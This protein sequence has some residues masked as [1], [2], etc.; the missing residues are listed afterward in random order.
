MKTQT[1]IFT[2]YFKDNYHHGL[3]CWLVVVTQIKNAPS[4]FLL[5]IPDNFYSLVYIDTA[6]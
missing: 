6:A 5:D 2:C 4:I 1:K 3:I